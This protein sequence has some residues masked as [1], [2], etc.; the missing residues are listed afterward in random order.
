MDEREQNDN[1]DDNTLDQGGRLAGS[2]EPSVLSLA[3][4]SLLLD[5]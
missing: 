4:N 2:Q 3:M 1:G 5:P